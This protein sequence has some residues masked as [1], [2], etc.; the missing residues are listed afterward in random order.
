MWSYVVGYGCLHSSN[1]QLNQTSSIKYFV[2]AKSEECWCGGNRTIL[3]TSRRYLFRCY[4]KSVVDDKAFLDIN[5]AGSK[6]VPEWAVLK[7]ISSCRNL[8]YF[9]ASYCPKISDNVLKLLSESCSML[10]SLTLRGCR[11]VGF[12]KNWIY[13]EYTLGYRFQM[14]D[15]LKFHMGANN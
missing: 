4:I 7:L 10:D 3:P 1:V 14:Q 9:D 15:Y 8:K 5:M 6:N 11:Q 13:I 2:F 12:L